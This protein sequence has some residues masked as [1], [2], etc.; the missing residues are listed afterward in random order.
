L[1]ALPIGFAKISWGRYPLP[2]VEGLSV[3]HRARPLSACMGDSSMIS[4][5][6]NGRIGAG[7][8]WCG[9][10]AT[11]IDYPAVS[12]CITVTA[13]AGGKLVGA[14]L[15]RGNRKADMDADLATFG[16]TAE[17]LGPVGG[18]YIVGMFQEWTQA[19]RNWTGYSPQ[20]DSLY[21]KLRDVLGY[22][23]GIAT[24]DAS[25]LGEIA[26]RARKAGPTVTFSYATEDATTVLRH[27]DFVVLFVE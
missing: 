13:V 22:R 16:R 18:V 7:G 3:G 17:A 15:F 10:D 20:D 4:L 6:S 19:N 23:L 8:A 25:A 26:I 12:T 11:A 24:Y 2:M 1:L 27:T 21:N 14:H 9:V 5:A